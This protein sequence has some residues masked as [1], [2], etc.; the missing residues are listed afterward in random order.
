MPSADHHF[1]KKTARYNH[2]GAQLVGQLAFERKT[3]DKFGATLSNGIQSNEISESHH[4]A[5]EHGLEYT[6]QTKLRS[7]L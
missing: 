4:K 2:V 7:N 1:S 6:D 3:S 5:N